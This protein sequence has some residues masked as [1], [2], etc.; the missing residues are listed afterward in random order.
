M[1]VLIAELAGNTDP[2]WKAAYDSARDQVADELGLR[3]L[4]IA[5]LAFEG[6]AEAYGHGYVALLIHA[7]AAA[8]VADG[9][10]HRPLAA[11][12]GRQMIDP[13]MSLGIPAYGDEGAGAAATIQEWF[14]AP[15]QGARRWVVAVPTAEQLHMR[16]LVWL[17]VIAD[18]R[19]AR[20]AHTGTTSGDQVLRDE[21]PA[22]AAAADPR[23]R[24]IFRGAPG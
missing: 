8:E 7:V 21:L 3:V 19:I 2:D 4:D 11:A 6:G 16:V 18:S 24:R 1:N 15:P 12:H 5:D 9:S 13:D 23:R 20:M 14:P 17:H 22:T 10:A